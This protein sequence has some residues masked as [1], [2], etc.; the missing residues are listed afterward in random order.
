MGLRSWTQAGRPACVRPAPVLVRV[1][2]LGM[3]TREE[4]AVWLP[5]VGCAPAYGLTCGEPVFRLSYDTRVP[6]RPSLSPDCRLTPCC[7]ACPGLVTTQNGAGV[8]SGDNESPGLPQGSGQTCAHCPPK[9]CPV[10]VD[11]GSPFQCSQG[12]VR[13]G[14]ASTKWL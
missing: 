14:P 4:V 6:Q 11:M 5:W 1:E 8:P 9:S 2:V 7:L 3:A 10:G 12:Q 13:C